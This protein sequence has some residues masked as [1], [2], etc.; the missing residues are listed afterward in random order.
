MLQLMEILETDIDEILNQT[1]TLSFEDE[2]LSEEVWFL[3]KDDLMNNKYKINSAEVNTNAMIQFNNNYINL[4]VT[5]PQIIFKTN[6]EVDNTLEELKNDFLKY[7]TK[8]TERIQLIPI[9]SFIKRD[10][11]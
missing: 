1:F 8:L 4:I 2:N 11:N 6:E 5:I 10:I 9:F 7:Y 3:L